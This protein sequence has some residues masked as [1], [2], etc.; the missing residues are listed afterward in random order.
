MPLLSLC[1]CFS[2]CCSWSRSAMAKRVLGLVLQKSMQ[3]PVCMHVASTSLPKVTVCMHVASTSLPMV[4]YHAMCTSS[5]FL[6]SA[7]KH[8]V[9]L[10]PPRQATGAYFLS[11]HASKWGEKTHFGQ[12]NGWM[13]CECCNLE[14]FSKQC[15]TWASP[16]WAAISTSGVSEHWQ[17][18]IHL[19]PVQLYA[20]R[21]NATVQ[22]VHAF[23]MYECAV[24]LL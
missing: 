10:F 18:K 7:S 4:V 19:H 24:L 17:N 16:G 14:I 23:N 13:L 5:T 22:L 8:P 6:K 9:T 1:S 12:C 11:M 20:S 21:S 3:E 15:H 2:S